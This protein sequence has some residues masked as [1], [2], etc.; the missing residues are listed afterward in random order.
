MFP[1][2]SNFTVLLAFAFN[3][4]VCA[5]EV[6]GDILDDIPNAP[7]EFPVSPIDCQIILENV[8][9]RNDYDRI[10]PLM[11]KID[12][13]GIVAVRSF[14]GENQR[15]CSDD[16]GVCRVTLR[17]AGVREEVF[18]PAPSSR[19]F[20]PDEDIQESFDLWMSGVVGCG[21][22]SGSTE[23]SERD[24]MFMRAYN[25]SFGQ[26]QAVGSLLLQ[27]NDTTSVLEFSVEKRG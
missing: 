15:E 6:Y 5:G 2:F 10:C 20:I 4:A 3:L 1:S 18:D 17:T 12:T 8:V 25:F 16:H 21:P 13:I 23:L 9:I 24:G 27:W 26:L 22:F 19:V 14:F 7:A 11:C